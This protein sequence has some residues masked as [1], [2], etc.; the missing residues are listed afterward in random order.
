[1]LN[2]LI[3]DIMNDHPM[4]VRADV[5]IR[6][7]AHLLLRY[8][9]NG[10]LVMDPADGTKLVGVFTI[11]DLLDLM[12]AALRGGKQRMKA[13]HALGSH[14]VSDFLKKGKLMTLKPDDNAAKAIGLMHN[15]RAMTIP[16]IADGKLV[17]VVGRHDILNIAFA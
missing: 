9:I 10:V 8:R 6:N 14:P 15:K 12:G 13:L 17:G 3:S 16:V 11:R 1:M 4:C 7:A 2:L 5:S